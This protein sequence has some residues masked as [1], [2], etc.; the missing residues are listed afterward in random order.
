MTLTQTYTVGDLPGLNCGVCGMRSCEEMATRLQTSPE[1]IKRCIYLSD[2]RYEAR[3]IATENRNN[4]LNT[5]LAS[6][7]RFRLDDLEQKII[8]ADL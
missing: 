6:V 8:K 5:P 3:E 2:N 4:P 1:S 7:I